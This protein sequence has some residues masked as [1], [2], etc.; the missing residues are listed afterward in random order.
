MPRPRK[1]HKFMDG[2]EHKHCSRCNRWLLLIEFGFYGAAWDELYSRCKKCANKNERKI[3]AE[4][5]GSRLEA[6]RQHRIKYPERLRD[7]ELFTAHRIRLEDY[8]ALL[9]SQNGVC[10]ICRQPEMVEGK[11]LAVDHDHMTGE[12]R[13]LL[14]NLCNRILGYAKDSVVT[15]SSAIDYLE[16]SIINAGKVENL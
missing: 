9:K 3:Y 14:C 10:A 12:I 13:G 6:V 11:S 16:T 2:V 8:N 7:S 5:R 1:E 4:N 15:L